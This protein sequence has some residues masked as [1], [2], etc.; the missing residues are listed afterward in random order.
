M[1]GIR[2]LDLVRPV[3]SILP[4]IEQPLKKVFLLP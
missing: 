4:K 1:S 3:T 2:F